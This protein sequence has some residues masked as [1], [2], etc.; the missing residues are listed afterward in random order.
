MTEE[1]LKPLVVQQ[2]TEFLTRLDAKT[3]GATDEDEVAECAEMLWNRL[4][5]GLKE[6][7]ELDELLSLSPEEVR[8]LFN[9]S[10]F[11]NND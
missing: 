7:G 10:D 2:Y 4:I 11:A 3:Q 6:A 5:L 9:K 1:D 8:E